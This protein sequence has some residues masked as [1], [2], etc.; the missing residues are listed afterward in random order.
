VHD[1]VGLTMRARGTTLGALGAV[2]A[3]VVP[4]TVASATSAL[5]PVKSL[6]ASA[7][8]GPGVKVSWRWPQSASVRRVKIRF[9]LGSQAP[10]T[11][12]SG[13]AAGI[14]KRGRRS[15]TIY[16][17]VPDSTYAFAVFARGHGMTGG[18]QVVRAHTLDAPTISSTSLPPGALGTSYSATLTVS[19]STSGRWAVESGSL[20]AGLSL[21]G[22]HIT[23]TPTAVGTSSFVLRYADRHGA[24]T[25]A[26]VSI[27]VAEATPSPSPTATG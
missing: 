16:G 20:P 3:A 24:T 4:V 8:T 22:S 11:S 25:Y 23:G 19:N 5:P 18:R 27:T 21:S 17:L 10:P 13:D 7:M 26:G 2:V 1:G 14:V 15:L 12:S 9:V 6:H